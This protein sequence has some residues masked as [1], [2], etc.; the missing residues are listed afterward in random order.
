MVLYRA[1]ASSQG[2]AL[3]SEWQPFRSLLSG[4]F[5]CRVTHRP[6]ALKRC[7]ELVGRTGLEPVT[8]CV[9]C[10]PEPSKSIRGC[11]H[12]TA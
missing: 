8:P 11:M 4:L 3:L 10:K 2:E 1:L 6:R 5:S 9:S 7:S 12:W